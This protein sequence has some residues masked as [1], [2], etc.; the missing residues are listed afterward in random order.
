MEKKT[1]ALEISPEEWYHD[2]AAK[3]LSAQIFYQLN[4][5]GVFNFILDNQPCSIKEISKQ[6][7]LEYE[8]LETSLNYI[9]MVDPLFNIDKDDLSFS[10]F[11][12]EVVK[13]YS[14]VMGDGKK[15]INFFDVRVGGLG[16]VWNN[17]GNLLTSKVQYGKDI[18]RRSD[19]IESGLFTL[20]IRIAD[21]LSKLLESSGCR[22]FVEL[23]ADTGI[24]ERLLE[25]FADCTVTIVD[26]NSE[27]LKEAKQRLKSKGLDSRASFVEADVFDTSR[28]PLWINKIDKPFTVFSIHIH[29][30]IKVGIEKLDPVLKALSN[31]SNLTRLLLIEQPRLELKDREKVSKVRWLSLQGNLIIHHMIKS[32]KILPADTWISLVEQNGFKFLRRDDIN[33]LGFESL[34]F[35]TLD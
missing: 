25:I 26:R 23:A 20:S 10:A 8:T 31:D 1:I 18:V 3:Y 16:M 11:G 24:S 12:M 33:Y 13:R 6:L 27:K 7:N 14:R 19:Q 30:F 2:T 4:Q 35:K 15:K 32:G 17:I 9:C 22:H 28:W 29:E 5:V 34:L 21:S